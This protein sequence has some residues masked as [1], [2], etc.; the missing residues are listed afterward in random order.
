[1]KKHYE[2]L[3]FL[4]GLGVFFVLMLH[5]AFYYYHDIYDVDINNPSLIITLIGFL[6][7]FAGLFAIVSAVSYTTQFLYAKDQL[8]RYKHMLLSGFLLLIVAYL[9]F[10]FTGPGIIHFDT[11]SMDESIFVSLINQGSIQKLSLERLFYVDSLVM[12]SLNIFLMVFLFKGIKKYFNHKKID[13]YILI[14]AILFMIISYVRIPLYNVYL[15]AVDDKNLLI[16]SLLNWFVGKNNPIFPFFAFA[17]FG[18]WVGLLLKNDQPSTIKKKMFPVIIL[19]LIIGVAGYVLTPETMLERA[20]DPTWYFIMVIQVGL[21]LA[22]ILLG[23]MAFDF[24][25][26]K[27]GFFI[28]FIKRFGVAGLTPFFFEQI[29]SALIFLGINQFITLKLGI[30]G[31]ILYGLLLTFGWGMFLMFWEKRQYKYGLEWGISTLV[32]KIS[33]SSKKEKLEGEFDGR[34]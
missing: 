4:R 30:P 24:K 21:F 14:F 25:S 16:M 32:N 31:A 20:I 2:S 9:Y 22:M 23:L 29:V 15:N 18:V 19:S 5:T 3:D 28:K 10:I 8:K 11:R 27:D 34:S 6:L 17:L 1:M 12:L 7:M 13:L 26:K 33:P